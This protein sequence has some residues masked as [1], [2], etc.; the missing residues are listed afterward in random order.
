M[1]GTPGDEPPHEMGGIRHHGGVEVDVALAAVGWL[2]GKDGQ[3]GGCQ[4]RPKS[5]AGEMK[6]PSGRILQPSAGT[7]CSAC[8][9]VPMEAERPT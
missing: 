4:T 3:R 9:T 8:P 6:R 2:A 5:Q 7:L 1:M